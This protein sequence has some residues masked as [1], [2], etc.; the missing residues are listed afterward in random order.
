VTAV[1]VE[2]VPAAALMAQLIEGAKRK[3]RPRTVVAK[4]F[5]GA[6][7]LSEPWRNNA[8]PLEGNLRQVRTCKD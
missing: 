4:Q 7:G 5:R 3:T 6:Q 1:I 2:R 8:G